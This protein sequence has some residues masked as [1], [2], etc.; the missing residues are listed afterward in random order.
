MSSRSGIIVTG[1]SGFIGRALV[2]H[3]VSSG[4]HVV[5]VA[6]RDVGFTQAEV[7]VEPADIAGNAELRRRL[8]E[9][10]CIVHLAARA[11]C[12]GPDSAFEPDVALA[13]S[14]ARLAATAGVRRF[15]H[16]SS[17]GV[18]GPS[19][20]GAAFT[21]TSTPAPREPYA[22]SK[23]RAETAVR[24]ALDSG[25]TEW[26]MLRPPMVYGAGAPGNFARLA[27]A[28]ERG[29]PL[30]FAGVQNRRQLVGIENLLDAL[31]LCM[32]HPAAS[33]KVFH[34]SDDE[35]LST[36]ELVRLVAHGLGVQPR[37]WPVPPAL[38]EAAARALGM[39][40][41]AE[42]LL[43]DLEIDTA[44]IRAMLGWRAPVS[45]LE[46]IPRAAAASRT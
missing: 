25:P 13:A 18:L 10:D 38:L 3:L 29:W 17:I 46:G 31:V 5:A 23:L 41:M 32:H 20:R 44:R 16:L 8:G 43:R 37:L 11:H 45:A 30:P 4:R 6:R 33:R 19:T 1:A 9:C 7:V 39:R 21:E 34:V 36:P 22:R 12:A 40:R 35:A 15:V 14:L 27:R 26:V 2:E 24:E 28:V 42:S